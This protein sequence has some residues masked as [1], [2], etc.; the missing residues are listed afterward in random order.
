M[1]NS[2]VT[3]AAL[4]D[5]GKIADGGNAPRA[6]P[7][8]GS[9]MY[10]FVCNPKFKQEFHGKLKVTNRFVVPLY[11]VGVLPVLG[12]GKTVML[13]TTK[14]RK[15]G[16]MRGFPVGYFR[17]DGGIYVFSAW[18]EK[19]NWF[20]NLMLNP[21][22]VYVQIGLSRF[23]AH[24]QVIRDRQELVHILTRLCL[25]SPADAYS[26]MG[27]DATRDDPA[28]SDFSLMMDNVLIVRFDKC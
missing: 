14:G 9:R 27:W 20:K 11:R 6:F 21:D 7:L 19:A 10:E 5:N 16:K 17:I 24:A 23:R 2:Q 18:G 1:H 4:R 25:D 26:M 12:L 22:Q 8:P 15:S 13:L 28:T 3:P